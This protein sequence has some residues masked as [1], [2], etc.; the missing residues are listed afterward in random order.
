MHRRAERSGFIRMMLQGRASREGYALFLLNL[1]PAYRALE[2]ALEL[3]R[4]DP[5]LARLAVRALYRT[6]AIERDLHVLIGVRDRWPAL[7]PAGAAYGAQVARSADRRLIAHAYV[8]YLGDLNGGRIL[9]RL[10][11]RA[12]G[13]ESEALGF[14][15]YPEIQDG[16]LFKQAYR[17]AID[18]AVLS[19]EEEEAVLDE[20]C[21]AFEL[22]I[23]ISQEV[24]AVLERRS[25]ATD[26]SR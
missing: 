15:D 6:A 17:A 20:S 3:G 7:L 18:T 13:L 23:R 12:P 11:A 25:N 21:A 5:C 26:G 19:P 1:L 22:N 2:A 16:N 4:A 24:M 10:L 8:R 14:Y 9:A